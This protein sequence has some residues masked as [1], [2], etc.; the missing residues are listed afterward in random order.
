MK[1]KIVLFFLV[2]AMGQ[3]HAQQKA[4]NLVIVT[5]DG[6][7]WQEVYKGMDSI[8]AADKKFNQEDSNYLFTTYWKPTEEARRKAIFPFLWS[9]VAQ[10]G[11][12]Y[13]NRSLGNRVDNANPYWFSYPGYNEIITG[14][15][16]TA[17][18]SNDYPNNPNTNLLEFLN[19]RP[20][21]KGKVSAFGAWE[22]FNRI[23][24]EP[25]SGFPVTAAFDPIGGKTPGPK[26]S[27]LNQMLQDSYK[28]FGDG[29]C[30]DVFTHYAA[31]QYLQEKKPRVL[32]I[33]Y[34]ET[35]EFAHEGRYKDYLAA[36]HHVDTWLK[37]IWDYLQSTEQYRNKTAL[38]IT[39]DHGRGDQVKSTWTDHGQSVPDAHEI[40]FA[41]IGAG[42]PAKGEVKQAGQVFQKQLAQTLANLMGFEFKAD[43]PVG[44]AIRLKN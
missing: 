11:Q 42:I 44:E 29:E 8:I 26:E 37:S 1:S 17:V 28:P 7:R 13:G 31:M 23:F 33:G 19:Q 30:L 10:K 16:D 43:H 24:N 36:A 38:L 6:L 12:L 41:L 9:V 25:R 18:N 32:F 15:P 4:E 21:F 39:V 14:Y 20:E 40:W 3:L 27:L 35:D 22:A 34:G 2:L 5:I